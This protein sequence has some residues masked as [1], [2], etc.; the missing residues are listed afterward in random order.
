MSV[1]TFPVAAVTDDLLHPT[2]WLVSG[3]EWHGDGPTAEAA[4]AV[5]PGLIP[6]NV[7]SRDVYQVLGCADL[8][9]RK[10]RLSVVFF[11]DLTR[12]FAAAGTSW[13]DL[14]VDWE[15]ACRELHNGSF[16]AV[17]LTVDALAHLII[18]DPAARVDPSSARLEET[19]DE[20][21]LVRHAV[22]AQ[23]AR[24]WPAYMRS[25]AAAGRL[26]VAR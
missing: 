16:P 5:A 1:R 21:E 24:E 22:A 19:A 23:L 15:S 3:L 9:A 10:H 6:R 12:M 25:T 26:A 11:S 7:V 20:R 14:G 8:Y 13:S 18:C 17:Y 4:V 2:H